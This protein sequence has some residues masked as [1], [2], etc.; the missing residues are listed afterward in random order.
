MRFGILVLSLGIISGC[1]SDTRYSQTFSNKD[2]QVLSTQKQQD[3]KNNLPKVVG[4]VVGAAVIAC[5]MI[6]KKRCMAAGETL[7]GRPKNVKYARPHILSDPDVLASIGPDKARIIEGSRDVIRI[8]IERLVDSVS[9]PDALVITIEE[10]WIATVKHLA[11]L[12]GELLTR[13]L[14][15]KSKVLYQIQDKVYNDTVAKLL[16]E[17]KIQ[18]HQLLSYVG[19]D[20]FFQRNGEI[21][22]EKPLASSRED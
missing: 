16:D 13:V 3:S 22:I 7:L 11:S 17:G 21:Y 8:N 12:D 10:T 18:E 6:V 20:R 5:V 1:G 2:S 9:S 15:E 19:R 4:I 14:N